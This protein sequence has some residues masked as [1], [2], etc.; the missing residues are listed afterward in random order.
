MRLLEH[1]DALRRPERFADLLL[2][3]ECDARG[4]TGFEDAEYP[5][6]ERLARALVRALAVDTAVVAGE[7]AASGLAGPAVGDAI[8]RARCAAMADDRQGP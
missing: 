1:C 8:R 6:R 7:A 5:Q 2:A 4:R 3:C